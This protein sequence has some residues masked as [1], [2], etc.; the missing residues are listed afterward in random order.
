[1]CNNWFDCEENKNMSLEQV[2]RLMI[3]SS[4]NGCPAFR[5]VITT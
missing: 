4:E 3:V 2:L 1:M 5:A